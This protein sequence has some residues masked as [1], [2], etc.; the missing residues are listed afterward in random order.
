MTNSIEI[1]VWQGQI[2]QLEMDA[3]VVPANESLFMTTGVAADVKRHAGEAVEVEAVA[4]GPLPAGAVTITTGGKLATPYII[5]AV[6][7]GHD[8]RPDAAALE[9]AL[10]NVLGMSEML[11]ATRI[12]I[13]LLGTERGVHAADAAAAALAA[14]LERHARRPERALRSVVVVAASAADL[15]AMRGALAASGSGAR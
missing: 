13:P 4:R 3:I 2:A 14:A 12:A 15:T 6:A 1:D 9:Q 7:V 11:G 10:D 8:L 5:H